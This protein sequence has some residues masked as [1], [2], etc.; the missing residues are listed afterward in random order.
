M[1]VKPAGSSAVLVCLD[2]PDQVTGLY[3]ELQSAPPAGYVDAIPAAETVMVL[4]DPART[5]AAAIAAWL[6]SASSRAA[7]T[8]SADADRAAPLVTIPV[9]YDGPDL[10][11]IASQ[12][13]L[14]IE[15]VV[16]RHTAN[17]YVVA[18]CGFAPG[19]G[20]LTGLDPMLCLPRRTVPRTRIPARSVAIADRFASVYPSTS[21]G[22]WHLLGSTE[23]VMWDLR[24]QPPALLAPGAR[25]RF[26]VAK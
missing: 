8:H 16:Y 7:G 14:S 21:P 10:A 19:F 12:T 1:R 5:Q 6:E 4:F 23:A 22:G 18:F 26:E 25:V 20:Y 17:E 13:G 3:R 24:R 11:E 15:E 2:D 9:R